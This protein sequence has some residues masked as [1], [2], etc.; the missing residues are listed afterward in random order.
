MKKKYLI[1]L[2]C[3]FC[4]NLFCQNNNKLHPPLDIPLVLSGTFGEL[5][6]NHFHAGI[7]IKTNAESGLKVYSINDG[8][9][10]RIKISPWGYG[11]AIYIKHPDGYTSVY[12]H[13]SRYNLS[14]EK[15]VKKHQY[16]KESYSLDLFPLKNE[17]LI[18]KG[19]LIAFSGNTGSSSAPH[20]HFEIRKS[21]NQFPQNVLNFGFDIYDDI[22]PTIKEIKISP[23]GKNS[24]INFSDKPKIYTAKKI[25]KNYLIKDTIPVYGKVSTGIY[26]Y[27]LL[28]G[29]KNKNGVYSVELKIDNKT[30]YFHEMNEFSFNE[31]KYI[32]SHID[33]AEKKLNKKNI[34]SCYLQENNNLSIYKIFEDKGI[35]KVDSV[36]F[37]EF[38]VKDLHSNISKIKFIFKSVNKRKTKAKK[39]IEFKKITFPYDKENIFKNENIEVK[40]PKMALY[41]TLIFKYHK[42]LDT[43]KNCFSPKYKIHNNKTALHKPYYISIKNSVPENLRNKAFIC[44]VSKKGNLIY[45]GGTWNNGKLSA[46]IRNFGDF[47]VSIDTIPPIITP[48]NIEEGKIMKSSSIRINI[49]DKLSGVKSYRGEIN[50]SW[51]LMEYDPKRNRL[52]HFFEKNLEK[53]KHIFKLIIVDNKE[54]TS[55]YEV[56]FKL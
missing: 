50:G 1:I 48:L 52:T 38:I 7:D 21:R 53:G 42:S 10:Y 51:I 34:H 40:I 15:Y 23:H 18:N 24:Q 26:T 41:D 27:D 20:L 12:A 3:T 28:N 49:E 6:T 19:D 8:Y 30:I 47:T 14:I 5:R 32:N 46:E 33:Y 31:T 9:V 35:F 54:N 13:L 43:L 25:N 45:K 4:V 16:E 2:L 22:A 56:N 39:I 29:A 17:I 44:E 11:K 37:G 55:K 36:H